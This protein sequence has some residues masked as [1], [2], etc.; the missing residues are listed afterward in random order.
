ML[1]G[2]GVAR[3]GVVRE[4]D[5]LGF[6]RARVVLECGR[7]RDRWSEEK[8]LVVCCWAKMGLG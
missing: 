1:L 3:V 7:A 4:T 8:R 5:R 6:G 2:R